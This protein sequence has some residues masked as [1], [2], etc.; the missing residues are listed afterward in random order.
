MVFVRLLLT[1]MVALKLMVQFAPAASVPPLKVKVLVPDVPVIVA[2]GP[3]LP[4]AEGVN[5][6]GLAMIIPTGIVSVKVMPVK[7]AAAFG[8]LSVIFKVDTAPPYTN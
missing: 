4:T 1:V 5:S 6:G 7:T 2:P 3:Q 8:F